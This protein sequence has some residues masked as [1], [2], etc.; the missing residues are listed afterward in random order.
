MDAK[1]PKPDWFQMSESGSFEPLPKGKKLMK[2]VA[3]TSPLVFLAAGTLFAQTHGN[4]PA[5]TNLAT[6]AVSSQVSTQNTP[7]TASSAVKAPAVASASVNTP[8]IRSSATQSKAQVNS[9]AGTTPAQISLISD[10][11]TSPQVQSVPSTPPLTM[12]TG[13]GDDDSEGSDSS[14]A[15]D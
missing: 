15:E 1:T 5:S 4:A 13:G 3:L 12:P 9:G 10:V 7:A 2:V 11:T 6:A 14:D 8:V